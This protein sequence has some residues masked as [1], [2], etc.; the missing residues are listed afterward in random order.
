MSLS[1]S[2]SVLA[3][4]TGTARAGALAWSTHGVSHPPLVADRAGA[5]AAARGDLPDAL[6]GFEQRRHFIAADRID[7]HPAAPLAFEEPTTVKAGKVLG[8]RRLADARSL[9]QLPDRLWSI[10]R[11]AAQELQARGVGQAG[12]EG[13]KRRRG[14]S[15]GCGG[16]IHSCVG[17]S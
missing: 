12:K 9:D 5:G 6:A 1:V 14:G 2:G 13:G 7:D 15:L 10:P 11:Q 17:I 4:R 8:H 3:A 16:L